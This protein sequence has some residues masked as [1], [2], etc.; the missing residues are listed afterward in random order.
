MKRILGISCILTVLLLSVS[1]IGQAYGWGWS[2]G[3]YGST[4]PN[5]GLNGSWGAYWGHLDLK[6]MFQ[7]AKPSTPTTPTPTPNV[8]E[9]VHPEP[10]QPVQPQPSQPLQPLPNRV[11]KPSSSLSSNEK[12]LIDLVN[13]ER[14]AAGL[15]PLEVDMTLVQLAKDKSHEMAVTSDVSHYSRSKFHANLD[16]AGVSYR[17]AGENI[18][19]ATSISRVHNGLMNSSGHRANIMASSYTHIG[20]GVV[21]YGTSY[22]AT[23]IFI[24][25]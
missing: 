20:V 16:A 6:G 4:Y 5:S 17:Q 25:R 9:P 2:H 18:A 22:Y 15:H 7:P 8:P 3:S 19:R 24:A 23:Q 11:P 10:S 12:E 1:F 13:K 21:K 14:V